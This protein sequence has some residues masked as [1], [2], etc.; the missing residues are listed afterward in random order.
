MNSNEITLIAAAI[1]VAGSL[2]AAVVSNWHNIAPS[3]PKMAVEGCDQTLRARGRDGLSGAYQGVVH[4]RIND[5]EGTEIVQLF[6]VRNG[7]A[8]EGAYLRKGVCGKVVGEIG[9]DRKLVFY[10]EWAGNSGFGNA[11]WDEDKLSVASDHGG[12]L[13]MYRRGE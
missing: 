10:W 8:V 6:L 5:V 9:L 11:I 3:A 2:I 7:R 1:G 4:D 12:F 13:V